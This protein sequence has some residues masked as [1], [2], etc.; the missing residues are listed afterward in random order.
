MKPLYDYFYRFPSESHQAPGRCRV[1]LYR[2]KNGMHTVLLTELDS[3][4]GESIASACERIA[5]NLVA[6]RGLNPKTTRWIQHEPQ[7]DDLPQAF[8]ELQFT[9]D[10]DN[11]ASDPQWQ[12]ID[13][14]QV[15]TLTGASLE[16]IERRLGD[17]GPRIKE[18]TEHVSNES[19][20]AQGTA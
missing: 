14:E 5:T 2:R 16:D 13:A 4:S 3:N 8:D 7:H 15:E 6:V 18:E 11:M 9:W 12:R 17:P 20:E 10:D 1:R 19:Y